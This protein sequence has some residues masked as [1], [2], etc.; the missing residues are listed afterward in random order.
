MIFQTTKAHSGAPSC[1]PGKES[2]GFLPL[3]RHTPLLAAAI[4]A[5]LAGCTAVGP[6]YVAPKLSEDTEVPAQWTSRTDVAAPS[7]A[8][9][10]SPAPAT[11]WWTELS[12]PVLDNLVSQAFQ[13][14]P[15]LEAAL[16]RVSQSRSQYAQANASALPSAEANAGAQRAKSDSSGTFNES[17]LSTNASWEID[18]FGAVRR[19]KEGAQARA[20]A[21]QAT[22][23]DVRVSLSADVTDAYL[24]YRACQS[25]V[26]LS[27]QDV[28]SRQATEKLTAASVKE[29]FTAPYQAIRSRASVAEAKTQ[30]AATRAYCERQENLLTRLTGI[31]RPNLMQVLADKPTGLDRL[32]MPK[33][34]SIAIPSQALTQRPDIRSAE[35]RLAAESADIGLAEAD[36]Y[37]RLTLN[38][39]LGYSSNGTGSSGALSFASWSFGPSLSLPIF[40]AGRRKAAVEIAKSK[41]EEALADFKAKTRSAIQEVEDALTRYAAANERAENAR[42]SASQ[43]QSFFDSVDVRYREGASNLLELED[44]RRAMLSAQQTLLSVQQERLQAWVAL[45]RATGGAA[46]Y[47][48]DAPAPLDSAAIATPVPVN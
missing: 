45:N 13:T 16:A 22:L 26:A 14:S 41:Y 19:G 44:A 28:I 24:S 10:T 2:T 33:H 12:D 39:A 25:Y 6:N 18:L 9:N 8:P 20:E 27:E 48:P 43:Y 38:G 7:E 17:W 3:R 11:T 42:I 47:E 30:L 37:P 34:F 15:T 32:P 46:R 21:Q 4:A 31:P 36:R 40:D 5:L 29:G 35:R 1:F 23:A